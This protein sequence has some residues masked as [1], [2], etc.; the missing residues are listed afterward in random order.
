MPKLKTNRSA[1]KRFRKTG[2]GKIKR[3]RAYKSHIL[4]SKTT[5]RKRK[6]RKSSLISSADQK[7]IN[8][9]IPY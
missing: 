3:N 9:L 7:R 6:L 1:A 2:T 8:A 4:T 5:K